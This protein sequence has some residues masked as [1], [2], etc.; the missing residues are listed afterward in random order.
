MVEEW[1]IPTKDLSA[2]YTNMGY[3]EPA[4]KIEN[5]TSLMFVG[6]LLERRFGDIVTLY[7][8]NHTAFLTEELD[9]W[10]HGGLADMG[11]QVQWKW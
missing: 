6:S 11:T 8:A 4:E 2:I 5:C 3:N 9:L 7:Y 1:M 10:Y